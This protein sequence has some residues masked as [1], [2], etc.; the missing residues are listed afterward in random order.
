MLSL[1]FTCLAWKDANTNFTFTGT[2]CLRAKNSS[3]IE[4][5]NWTKDVLRL[6]PHTQQVNMIDY[7]TNQH[8]TSS[9]IVA[10]QAAD[11]A[12]VSATAAGLTLSS[13]PLSS[14]STSAWSHSHWIAW[15]L[16]ILSKYKTS[17][18]KPLQNFDFCINIIKIAAA[19][20]TGQWKK[21][22]KRIWTLKQEHLLKQWSPTDLTYF[23]Y[24]ALE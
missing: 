24:P 7:E 12:A 8:H 14:S 10:S 22:S 21:V 17:R 9:G 23:T 20:Q 16:F 15:A 1:L 6:V 19:I 11:A 2:P 5:L 4:K 13:T 3:P 18:V